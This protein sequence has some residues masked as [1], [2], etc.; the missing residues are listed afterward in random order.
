MDENIAKKLF[1]Y[2]IQNT[3]NIVRIINE[4]NAVFD[5]SD[6]GTGKTYTAIAACVQ[7]KLRPIII[8]PLAV[9]ATWKKVCL[10][11]NVNP[12][13][14]VNYETIKSGKYYDENGNRIKCEYINFNKDDNMYTWEKIENKKIIF[15]FD[16]VHRCTK[17]DTFNGLLL[18][19]TKPTNKPIIIL[20]AT[21]AD[22][23]EKFKIFAY[24]LNF[25]DRNIV[26]ERNIDFNTYIELINVWIKQKNA[27]VVIHNL[28]YPTKGTRMRIASIP[29]FPET[30]ITATPYSIEKKREMEI[31]REYSKIHDIIS[32]QKL[33][34]N[35]LV[36]L[37]RAH[38]RI[39]LLK[40][41]IFVDLTN[42][43]LTE[44]KSVVIFVNYTDTLQT[45]KNLLK[46][47]CIIWGQQ[48]D[49]ERQ[50]NINDF[51]ENTQK[52]IICNI[53]AGSVG[54]SFHDLTGKNPRVALLSPCWSSIDLVQALGRVHRA[55]SKSKS[56]QRIIYVANTVEEKIA[57][58]LENKLKDL[59]SINNGDLDLTNIDFQK[60]HQNEK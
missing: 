8:C 58:K 14:I 3:Q 51:Q 25:I 15:I 28:L 39:E 46:T 33:D 27:M 5:G 52:I 30:Q 1:S 47:E 21:I 24:I 35:P 57:E 20:S 16:E 48:T 50:K 42:D 31:E 32:K 54:I 9:M 4:N 18:S 13:F 53:K 19:S 12:F 59:N 60:R 56:L 10:Y 26:K 34:I 49:I 45:L 38:Q 11:F 7:L 55:G 40:I 29:N 23:P 22:T 6:T 37:L 36:A 2:Q 41:P 17:L 43:F 44:G